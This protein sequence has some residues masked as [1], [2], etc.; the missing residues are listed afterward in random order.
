MPT[1]P[2]APPQRRYTRRVRRT[3]IIHVP[4][5]P[6]AAL[7]LFEQAM[8]TS[9]TASGRFVVALSGGSTPLPLY[10]ALAERAELPWRQTWVFWGDERFVPRDHPDSNAG[11]AIAAFLADVPVPTEQL[12]PWPHLDGPEASA[13]AYARD[14]ER[15]LGEHGGFDLTLLG[16]GADGHTASLFPGTGAALR[17]E[18]TL[19][20]RP[21]GER[22]RLSLGAGLLSRSRTVA[23]LVEGENKRAA[24]EATLAGDGDL[25]RY[26][27]RA[28]QA[29]DR[30]VV[31]TDLELPGA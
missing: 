10:R 22:V 20:V 29:R 21:P 13:A 16:L 28:I 5:V 8:V 12:F 4:D 30:L 7:E 9:V 25:D 3:D 27:A 2:G 31:I 15:V 26:P 1:A 23:F 19:V 17:D 11:T 6:A 18:P 24:L 14:L